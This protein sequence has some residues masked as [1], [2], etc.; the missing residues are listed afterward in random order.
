GSS[1]SSGSGEKSHTCDEC[2]KN[3][4]YISALRIHQRVHMGEKCSGPSSG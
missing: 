2:G 4:C 3:F 1:G